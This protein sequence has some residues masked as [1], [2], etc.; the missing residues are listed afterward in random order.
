MPIRPLMTA[1]GAALTVAWLPLPSAHAA[2]WVTG[3]PLSNAGQAASAPLV[4]VTP[5]GDR[6]VAWTSQSKT[7]ANTTEGIDVR[8]APPGQDFGPIQ[9]IAS[10]SVDDPQFVVGADGTAA[11]VWDGDSA[12]HIA[13]RAPGATTFTEATALPADVNELD[14]AVD[15]G[16]VD[17]AY[18][19]E[20][21]TG[22]GPTETFDSTIRAARL[23]AGSNTVTAI[24]G[25]A[26]PP[27]DTATFLESTF[28]EHTVDGPSI[29]ADGGAVHVIWEDRQE[30]VTPTTSVTTIRRA[31]LAPGAAAFGALTTVDTITV[32]ST[33]ADDATPQIVAT[34]GRVEA[35]WARESAS[36]IAYE[37]VVPSSPIQTIPLGAQT[38]PFGVLAGVDGNGGL[39]LAWTNNVPNVVARVVSGAVVPAGGGPLAPVQLTPGTGRRKLDDLAVAPDGSAVVLSDIDSANS[40]GSRPADLQASFH[41]PGAP[42]PISGPRDRTGIG[43]FDGASAAVGPDGRAVAA[44]SADDGAGVF[45][46][47][48]FFSQRDATAPV[49]GTVAI[50]ATA[51]PAT[52]VALAAGATDDLT[53]VTIGWDFGDGS[54]ANGPSVTHAYGAPGTYTVTVTA[55]DVSGNVA[56]RTATISVASPTTTTVP[57]RKAPSIS[58]LRVTNAR[59][60]V[61]GR[62]TAVIARHRHASKKAPTGTT[63]KLTLSER[64]TVIVDLTGGAHHEAGTL[65]R[66]GRASGPVSIPFTGVIGAT[67]LTPGAYTASV[68]AI[69]AAGNRSRPRTVHFTVVA[70]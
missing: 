70:R 47:R 13:R 40:F 54:Q 30:R 59:F 21:S 37:G 27:L 38:F 62:A 5:S 1:I 60:K 58:S 39:S 48:I 24:P 35:A 55:T 64:A 12:L 23:S 29:A 34:G 18:S 57:D 36:Q 46:N 3:P 11:L 45:A 33:S 14:A 2:G 8:V 56:T 19:T 6:I 26:T 28:D 4:T 66:G 53:A 61:A 67:R 42:E 16:T 69:D 15:G 31:T 20:T 25:A 10:D 17:V 41:A 7:I 51:A 49:F 32:N 68:T 52:P 9:L 50:P 44:W 22:T 63:F 65:V 43:A